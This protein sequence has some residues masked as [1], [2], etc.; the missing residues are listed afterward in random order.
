M[1]GGGLS[2]LTPVKLK[3]VEEAAIVAAKEAARRAR[4]VSMFLLLADYKRY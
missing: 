4:L 3:V 2:K 1:W